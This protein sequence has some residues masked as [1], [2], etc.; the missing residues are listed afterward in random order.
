MNFN[1]KTVI[2]TG[3]SSGIGLAL[4]KEFAARN[5]HIII[6][7]RRKE[8]IDLALASLKLS[9]SG[10][11]Y[12]IV[13]DVE[14]ALQVEKMA[15]EAIELSGAPD[16]LVNS[17]G[18]VHPGH[19]LELDQEIFEWM[20]ETNLYGIVN[21][22]RAF[23]PSM[24]E[25]GSGH[26]VNLGSFA[27]YI[28]LFGYTAYGASKFAVRG[29]SEALRMEVKQKGIQ[30]HLVIPP[31]T[32]TPQLAYENLH[33]PRELQYLFP[34]LGVIQPEQVARA[35]IRGIERGRFEIIPDLGSKLLLLAENIF[36]PWKFHVLDWLLNRANQ[37]IQRENRASSG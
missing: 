6:S 10:K 35:V 18:V 9:G 14:D 12:G 32:D 19:F 27:S 26:I 37:R 2:I 15:S 17:A 36:R 34:E 22:T 29:F 24:I 16:I 23:L 11:K 33:K 13:C 3:G 4:A 5:A 31:D 30:V 20:I 25:R 1:A 28:G 21:T 8:A 7:S